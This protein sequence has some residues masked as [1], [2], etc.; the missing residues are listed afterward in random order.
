MK[1][2]RHD[3]ENAGKEKQATHKIKRSSTLREGD[4][5]VREE[6]R[7]WFNVA[8]LDGLEGGGKEGRGDRRTGRERET[9]GWRKP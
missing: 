7:V 3:E 9:A 8:D 5:V 2:R 4:A 1:T 6:A